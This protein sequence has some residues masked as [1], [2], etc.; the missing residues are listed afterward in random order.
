MR[1]RNEEWVEV[2]TMADEERNAYTKYTINEKQRNLK[3][4]KPNV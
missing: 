2:R 1:E 3:I 4:K